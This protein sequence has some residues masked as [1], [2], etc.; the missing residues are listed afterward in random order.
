[1]ARIRQIKPEFWSSPST[2]S[3]SAVARLLFIAMW[4][5]ADDSGHGTAN[6]KEL[7]GFAFPHD[8]V[9]ELSGGKCRNFRHCVAEVSG[10]FGVVFYNVR[11]RLYYEIPSWQNHQRNERLAKGKFPL[12]DEGEIVDMTRDLDP[13]DGNSRKVSE[14][15]TQSYGSSVAVS[16]EQRVIVSEGH[17]GLVP[18]RTKG[19]S[20]ENEAA[21]NA[22]PKIG[23]L[24]IIN[25]WQQSEA[26]VIPS[27][28]V[29]G[30]RSQ[31]A[32]MLKEGVPPE[33]I[34]AGM[35]EWWAGRFPP[36]T[37]PNYVSRVGRAA[38][39]QRATGTERAI[40][41]LDLAAQIEQEE[42]EHVDF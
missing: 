14:L 28:V 9:A 3:A 12:P 36:S 34:R 32:A 17:R 23:T 18:L 8:D 7:E 24:R 42:S 26:V 22:D 21:L 19:T 35:A 2:A 6:M 40:A 30:A 1:M 4:N 31:V 11:G 29:N 20:G 38:A 25:D 33:N 27:Q 5:W 10:S 15:P 16:E 13:S 39:P 37:L 41:T